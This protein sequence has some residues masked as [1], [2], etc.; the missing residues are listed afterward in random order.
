MERTNYRAQDVAFELTA[1]CDM[2]N[3]RA[4][5]QRYVVLQGWLQK[6]ATW[7]DCSS[8]LYFL[9]SCFN[10]CY[11]FT[12]GLK[13]T[14]IGLKRRGLLY[15]GVYNTHANLDFSDHWCWKPD[16]L[17]LARLDPKFVVFWHWNKYQLCRIVMNW[18][19]MSVEIGESGNSAV[20]WKWL[21][22]PKHPAKFSLVPNE[23]SHFC[24]GHPNSMI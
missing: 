4:W 22:T 8:P 16:R 18:S 3:E 15:K 6:V 20:S 10:Y 11:L 21:R 14:N 23:I 9:P 7:T 1:R 17:I 2:W 12:W 19:N 5:P 13:D 24:L